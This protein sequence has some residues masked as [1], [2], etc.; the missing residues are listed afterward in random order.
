MRAHKGKGFTLI[1]VMIVI[2]MLGIVA[3]SVYK[4]YSENS[5][6]HKNNMFRQKAMWALQS[7]AGLIRA[8][9]FKEIETT[10]N[11]P[12]SDELKGYTGLRDAKG[13]ITVEAISQDLKRVTLVITWCGARQKDRKLCMTIYRYKL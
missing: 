4:I 5:I 1:E 3:I 9:P 6:F 13:S 7:H 11:S 12:F 8:T 2:A 10:Q